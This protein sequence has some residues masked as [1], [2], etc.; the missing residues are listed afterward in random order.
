M[1]IKYSCLKFKSCHNCSKV[2]NMRLT[3]WSRQF[4]IHRLF[5]LYKVPSFLKESSILITLETGSV[6]IRF[7]RIK[8]ISC[9]KQD[10]SLHPSQPGP[11]P[12]GAWPGF[13]PPRSRLALP[14]TGRRRA[15]CRRISFLNISNVF[16]KGGPGDL[17]RV[18][19]QVLKYWMHYS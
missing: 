15:F 9:R 12:L 17:L 8:W 10:L 11:F 4:C 14:G 16:G 2:L 3:L 5:F 19:A 1:D 7:T 13:A 6:M 18:T